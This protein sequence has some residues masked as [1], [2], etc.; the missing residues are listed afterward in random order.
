MQD[1]ARAA[2]QE[3]MMKA[4]QEQRKLDL[5]NATFGDQVRN[6][7]LGNEKLEADIAL[8]KGHAGPVVDFEFSP[9]NDSLLATASQ[10]GTVKLW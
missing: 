7:A 5:F 6:S 2:Q 8:I 9:Y 3:Q 1:Q 10:D 4:Q